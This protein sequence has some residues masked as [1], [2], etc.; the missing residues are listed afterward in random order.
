MT[1]K[2]A[3]QKEDTLIRNTTDH[4]QE[5]AKWMGVTIDPN[6]PHHQSHIPSFVNHRSHMSPAQKKAYETL[7]DQFVIPFDATQK[8]DYPTLFGREAPTILEIGFGMGETTAKI[9]HSRP[10]DQFIAL[11]IYSAGVGA[12]LN[13]IDK[14]NIKNVLLMQH[15]AVEVLVHMVAENSLSGVH[16]FFPDP[17]PKKRHHKRRLIQP[18]FVNLLVSRLKTGGYIHCATD[19]EEYA[20]QMLEVLSGHVGLQNTATDYAE[21]PAYRP[22]TKFENRGIKLGYNV[23]DLVFKKI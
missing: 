17:W 15:D 8:L 7:K 14:E 23:H 9:A 3:T 13:R 1:T 21:K 4:I 5:V 20:E 12:M 22:L 11:E 10:E 19:W 16:I 6:N 18:P 2:E